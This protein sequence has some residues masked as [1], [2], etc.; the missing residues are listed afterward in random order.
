MRLSKDNK[1][2]IHVDSKDIK[3]GTFKIPDG[4][5]AIG[6]GAFSRSIKLKNFVMN[7]EPCK[8]LKQIVIPDG[9]TSIGGWAFYSCIALQAISL[10]E[11]LKFI[12]E[13]AFW[14]C[15]PQIIFI[16]SSDNDEIDRIT[17]LLPAELQDK[18]SPVNPHAI[19]DEQLK[20]ILNSVETN[21]LYRYF[22]IDTGKHRWFS[23]E[24]VVHINNFQGSD[25]PYYRK[26]KAL[27]SRVPLPTREEGIPAY[28]EKI[29]TIADKCIIKAVEFNKKPK[30]HSLADKCIIKAVEFNKKP[31]PCS[32]LLNALT[33]I[34]AVSASALIVAALVTAIVIASPYISIPLLALGIGCV[35]VTAGT[36]FYRASTMS[37]DE[38]NEITPPEEFFVAG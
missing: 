23:N 38:H 26:A 32:F 22:N 19:W 15:N 18:I 35:A 5:T 33:A 16:N 21:E 11:S 12:D 29:K 20:R 28:K 27:M 31:K 17:H 37:K 30:P 9:V 3:G 1:T 25:N 10:P 2:L 8:R 6:E 14:N 7:I 24:I 13:L 4:V 36:F 34:A